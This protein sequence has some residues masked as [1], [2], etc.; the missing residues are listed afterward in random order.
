MSARLEWLAG[1][2]ALRS[3]LEAAIDSS[4]ADEVIAETPRRRVVR[5]H[6]PGALD[7]LALKHFRARPE[8]RSTRAAGVARWKRALGRSA[9]AREWRALG[10]LAAQELP[11]PTPRAH[12][13]RDDEEWVAM[14]F[15]AGRPLADALR[16]AASA[17]RRALID[18]LGR[19]LRRL[20]IAGIAHGDL[21]LGNI[22]LNEA[23]ELVLLDWQRARITHSPRAHARD[24][25]CLEFS[26]ARVGLGRG[27]RLRVRRS[28]LGSAAS[29][30]R[31][32]AAG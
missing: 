1:E 15:V 5:L 29:R 20:R 23:G 27:D 6:A 9:A 28:A 25:A 11:A 17:D 32:L 22:L 14:D 30:A 13:R 7:S 2:L 3:T 26:L 8:R 31:L 21:H 16:A 24:L 10:V 19:T 18:E 12:L 4:T